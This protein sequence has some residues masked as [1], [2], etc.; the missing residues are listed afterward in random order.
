M[1]L[2]R[3]IRI[4]LYCFLILKTFINDINYLWVCV[5]VVVGNLPLYVGAEVVA[6]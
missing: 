5:E 4:F 6:V 1:K 2:V 3:E